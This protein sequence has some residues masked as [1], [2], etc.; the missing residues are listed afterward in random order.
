VAVAAQSST[1]ASCLRVTAV[2]LIKLPTRLGYLIPFALVGTESAG[3]PMP[4]ETWR[5]LR[6]P[7]GE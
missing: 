5:R 7:A 1:P 6:R 4:G 2:A 3:V